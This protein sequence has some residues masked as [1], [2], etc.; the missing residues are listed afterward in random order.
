MSPGKRKTDLSRQSFFKQRKEGTREALMVQKINKQGGTHQA[1]VVEKK[2]WNYCS[3][4]MGG[5]CAGAY[6]I[7]KP[8]QCKGKEA[9]KFVGKEGEQ[10]PKA[11]GDS[12]NTNSKLKLA[13]AYKT[14]I[15]DMAS[16]SEKDSFDS[17]N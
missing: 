2:N 6:H 10:K 17:Q 15:Q 14:H 12:G 13:K 7:H 3:P 5:K 8:S 1:K 11:A 9:Y 16:D 4:K